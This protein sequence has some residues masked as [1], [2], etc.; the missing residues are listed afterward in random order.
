MFLNPKKANFISLAHIYLSM[1]KILAASLRACNK[2]L[3][4]G[5]THMGY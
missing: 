4:A 1:G 2:E 5:K 3:E